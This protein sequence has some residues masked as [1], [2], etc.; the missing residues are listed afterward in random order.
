MKPLLVRGPPYNH[1]DIYITISV[2]VGGGLG[3]SVVSLDP[4]S[5]LFIAFLAHY[6]GKCCFI[7]GKKIDF[8]LEKN[9]KFW[10]NFPKLDKNRSICCFWSLL[11]LFWLKMDKNHWKSTRKCSFWPQNHYFFKKLRRLGSREMLI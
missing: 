1:T 4:E 5:Y 6:F 9:L 2:A 7:K 3:S 8:F 10:K 11:V